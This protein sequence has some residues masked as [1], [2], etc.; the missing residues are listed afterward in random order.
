VSYSV[1]L[2]SSAEHDLRRLDARL[3]AR[4]ETAIERLASN[5]RTAG[6][7]KPLQGSG[8][9]RLRVGKYRVIYSIDDEAKTVTVLE[10]VKRGDAY[11]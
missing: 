7:V 3:R 9:W 11:R 2:A 10:V 5:P 1:G 6:D 4:V 8:D